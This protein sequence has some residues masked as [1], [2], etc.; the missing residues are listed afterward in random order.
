MDPSTFE[1]HLDRYGGDL[2]SWPAPLRGE[3]AA[4]LETCPRARAAFAALGHA[5]AFLRVRTMPDPGVIETTAAR[6][7]MGRQAAPARRF[8]VGAGWAAAAV[9]LLGLG[10]SLGDMPAPE[11]DDSPAR[12]ISAALDTPVSADVE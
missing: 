9:V 6:A 1:D 5:E 7:A 4:L 3:A 11:H 2:A 8:A 10:I 12:I